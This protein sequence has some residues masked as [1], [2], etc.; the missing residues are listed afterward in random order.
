MYGETVNYII[1]VHVHVPLQSTYTCTV[2]RGLVLYMKT[3]F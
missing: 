1:H 2:V 3:V